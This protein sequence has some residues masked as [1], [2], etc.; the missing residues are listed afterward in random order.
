MV[1]GAHSTGGR[2][3]RSPVGM[4]GF[5]GWRGGR[6]WCSAPQPSAWRGARPSPSEPGPP[7]APAV[8]RPPRP[9]CPDARGGRRLGGG[10]DRGL[11]VGDRGQSGARRGPRARSSSST[12]R[13]WPGSPRASGGL[14]R[15][16]RPVRRRSERSASARR[17]TAPRR[18]ANATPR[19]AP[20]RSSPSWPTAESAAQAQRA[21]AC[22][23]AQDPGLARDLCL[24]AASEAQH[25]A[26]LD[27]L[28]RTGVRVM[29]GDSPYLDA[30]QAAVAGEHAA[31]WASGR[32]AGELGG[33]RRDAARRELDA[34]RRA[35]DE[36]RRQVTALGAEPVE[37]AV[38]Y[39]E[40]F[41]VEGRFRWS[42]THG[43]REHR[44]GG[45]VRRRRR[46]E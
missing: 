12:R 35:R 14:G 20:R 23:G 43:A 7:S 44:P 4:R 40:P 3:R 32:A 29:S 39:V 28:G 37:A 11:S 10:A 6:S 24:I 45:H 34:H 2:A 13:T 17:P 46:R 1:C 27:D 36:L 16:S 41:P 22:D 42:A 26:A 21:T 19:P 15:G 38:A 18:S 25:A 30:L 31:V 33:R 5:R 8:C 9:R